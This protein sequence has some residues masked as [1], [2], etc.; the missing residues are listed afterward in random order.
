[1]TA[2]FVTM[3]VVT[4]SLDVAQAAGA[5]KQPQKTGRAAVEA[6]D[7]TFIDRQE[8]M[9]GRLSAS[10]CSGCI[11]AANRVAPSSYEKPG[12]TPVAEAKLETVKTAVRTA[13][14]PRRFVQLK[15]RYAKHNRRER[16]KLAAR[17][18]LRTAMLAKRRALHVAALKRRHPAPARAAFVPAYEARSINT[19]YRIP[20]DQ[21]F[22][23]RD[24]GRWHETILP[25]ALRMR[26][27]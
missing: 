16:L 25:T 19:V 20:T 5:N 3:A 21:P 24:D 26:R 18:R 2:A 13:A 15:K 10:I 7:T 23:P 14:T 17:A 11:T 6:K 22:T 9:W 12:S 27:G 4:P 1:M 8:K